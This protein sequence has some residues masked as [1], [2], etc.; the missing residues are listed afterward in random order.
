[1]IIN[2]TLEGVIIDMIDVKHL[3]KSFGETVAVKD[4]SFSVKQGEVLGFLG[5]NGAGKTTTMRILA[6]FLSADE[7]EANIAG[8]DVFDQSLEVRKHIGYLPESAPLYMDLNVLEYLVFIAQMH[9]IPRKNRADRI[10]RM[11]EVCG[12]AGV[13]KKGIATLSKGYR[14]RV[15]LAQ[16]MIHDPS[17]LILD[18]PTSG[19]DPNQIM[20]IR[21]LI[22]QIGQ[23][24]TVIL[25]T[26]ILPEVSATCQRV[27]IINQGSIVADGTPAELIADARGEHRIN[28]SLKANPAD[29]ETKLRQLS[30]VTSFKLLEQD[31]SG[32]LRYE[33]KSPEGETLCEE[34]FLL[35]VGQNWLLTELRHDTLSLEEVF[36]QLTTKESP[37]A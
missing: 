29:V 24:K 23:Q 30:G 22:R 12:L 20:E 19:L 33:I 8:F 4:V 37:D 5:P 26:H 3:T 17:I 27:L 9:S 28:I 34:L 2:H 25:S 14:Q 18:E 16:A 21:E 36:M 15:G 11:V 32:R 13:L 1:M 31:N 35:A 10:N 6:G 7:G